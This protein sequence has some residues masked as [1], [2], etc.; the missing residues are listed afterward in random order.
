MVK[1]FSGMSDFEKRNVVPEIIDD[2][3]L[4]GSELYTNLEEIEWI[5]KYLGGI[6]TSAMPILK[7]IQTGNVKTVTDIG[8]GSGDIL[9]YIHT[10]CK[11]SPY[12]IKLV[13]VDANEFIIETARKNHFQ[14]IPEV[15]FVHADIIKQPEK[16]PPADI[17][18]LNL[19]LHHFEEEEIKSIVKNLI[20]KDPGL[21]VINDLERSKM[22]YWLFLGLCSVIGASK[23][24][25]ND[26]SL[27]IKKGFKK[28]ELILLASTFQGYSCTIRWKWAFRWQMELKRIT[29]N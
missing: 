16:I 26:G 12:Q 5:N 10:S 18:M 23:I 7:K 13:G 22:A 8:C 28:N 25:R 15:E 27:S 19:F 21:I 24:T 14:N 20:D 4:S 17:Y 1:I 29:K 9:K 3:E 6:Q 11:N 2:F